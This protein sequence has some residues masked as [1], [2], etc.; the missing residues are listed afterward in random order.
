MEP[1]NFHMPGYRVNEYLIVITPPEDLWQKIGRVKEEFSQKYKVPSAKYL[2]PHIALVNFLG[3]DMTE[4]KIIQRLQ[5]IA[6]GLIPFKIELK[7]Y[8]NY[9][10]HTIFVYVLS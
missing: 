5:A 6:M 7:D 10:C 8:G 9:L 3:L 1:V 2:K 4:E